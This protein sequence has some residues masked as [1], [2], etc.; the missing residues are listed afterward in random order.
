MWLCS[1]EAHSPY[2]THGWRTAPCR[3]GAPS[4]A[5]RSRLSQDDGSHRRKTVNAGASLPADITAM[6]ILLVAARR[7][8]YSGE[9]ISAPFQGLLSLAAVLRAGTFFETEGGHV[10][11][12]DEQLETLD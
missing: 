11:I 5:S 10:S 3:C 9:S 7:S 8:P 6:N 1:M 4:R 2:P 12:V